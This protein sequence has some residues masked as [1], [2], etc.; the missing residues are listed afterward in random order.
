MPTYDYLC[1]ACGHRFER[2][3]SIKAKPLTL[4]PQ[5]GEEKVARLISGGGGILF[6]GSGFY[7]TDY[8][9]GPKPDS[10][11]ESKPD[12]GKCEKKCPD[13]EI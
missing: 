13:K 4:C 7:S 8:R 2:F 3:E 11:P 9:K 10:K 1:D 5:C 12:C 6:K